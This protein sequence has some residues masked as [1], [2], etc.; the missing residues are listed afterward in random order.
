MRLIA[1]AVCL[2]A[3]HGET[4][5]ETFTAKAEPSPLYA[6]VN[7]SGSTSGFSCQVAHRQGLGAAE[8][9]W[10]VAIQC[11]N[12][13]RPR[14]SACQTVAEHSTAVRMIYL[15]EFAHAE[16]CITPRSVAVENMTVTSAGR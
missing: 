15:E 12:G 13:T 14:A 1:A 3:C 9:C 7:C 2:C 10:D 16:Q 6:T 11:L 4:E 5:Q 8:V